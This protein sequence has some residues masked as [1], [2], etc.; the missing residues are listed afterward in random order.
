MG[1]LQLFT[2]FK[3][4]IQESHP[5]VCF[6]RLKGKVLLTSKHNAEGIRERTEFISDYLPDVTEDLVVAMAKQMKC[7]EDDITDSICLAIVAN[8]LA[9]GKTETIP[10]EPM[11]DDTGLLMQMVIP[12]EVMKE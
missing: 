1:F 9:Q 8:M 12:K 5:E 7:N 2:Q 4:Q 11:A 3:N 6:A 10:S